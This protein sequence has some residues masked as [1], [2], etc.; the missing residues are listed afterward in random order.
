MPVASFFLPVLTGRQWCL[1]VL[2]V[3]L[4]GPSGADQGQQSA[5][6][7]SLQLLQW[8]GFSHSIEQANT[9]IAQA[10]RNPLI[11]QHEDHQQL[12]LLQQRL[13]VSSGAEVMLD[14]VTAHVAQHWSTV[15]AQSLD[16]LAQPLPSRV[17]NFDIAME[18]P[19]AIGKFEA[20]RQQQALQPVAAERIDLM[21][22]IDRALKTSA[23]AAL[24][25][26]ELETTAVL[27]SAAMTDQP[28]PEV[29][30]ASI[31]QH[32]RQQ[33]MA[34]LVVELHLYSYR[35]MK[36]DEL[37][38]YVVLLEQPTLQASVALSYQA[39]QRSLQAGRAM[40]LAF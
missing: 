4:A 1:L 19:G 33:Y 34:A 6:Q 39:L 30:T 27:L 10:L 24:L 38:A 5:N 22:R 32:Q 3:L 14:Q 13:L 17:R 36:D 26:T 29:D 11:R 8:L 35:F 16:I 18:M 23:V 28:R 12:K 25:Q 2:C 40:A 31:R 7:H 15:T 37:Q 20:F 9:A 21:K